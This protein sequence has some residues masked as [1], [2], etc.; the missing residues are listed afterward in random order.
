MNPIPRPV[1]LNATNTHRTA[2]SKCN[3]YVDTKPPRAY[4]TIPVSKHVNGN[5]KC[6][7][8]ISL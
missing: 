8:L 1:Y 4:V 6:Y 2:R 7:Y 3:G 5:I